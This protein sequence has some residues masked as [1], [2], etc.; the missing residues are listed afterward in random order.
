MNID[1]IQQHIDKDNSGSI[2]VEELKTFLQENDV[3]YLD[4]DVK[5]IMSELDK[6]N[7]GIIT[8]EEFK[9]C[10]EKLLEKLG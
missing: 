2:N 4:M 3:T 9:M 1:F 7:D 10:F 8:A 5:D 6:N